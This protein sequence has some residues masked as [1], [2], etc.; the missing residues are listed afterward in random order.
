MT[1]VVYSVSVNNLVMFPE[2]ISVDEKKIAAAV[3]SLPAM[4]VYSVEQEPVRSWLTYTLKLS[5][6]INKDMRIAL[7]AALHRV[8]TT[9][10]PGI[11]FYS[12]DDVY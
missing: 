11:T 1:K 3:N 4:Q 8:W 5:P 6:R 9:L 10:Y 12:Y 2:D 7:E